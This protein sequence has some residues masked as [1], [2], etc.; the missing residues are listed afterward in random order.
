MLTTTVPRSSAKWSRSWDRIPS[1]SSS[2]WYELENETPTTEYTYIRIHANPPPRSKPVRLSACLNFWLY[3]TCESQWLTE[4][5]L[6]VTDWRLLVYCSDGWCALGDGWRT[7]LSFNL[8]WCAL[9]LPG[10]E[11][12][13]TCRLFGCKFIGHPD[14]G[15]YLWYV[16]LCERIIVYTT[17]VHCTYVLRNILKSRRPYS[18]YAQRLGLHAT[19]SYFLVALLCICG[20]DTT[21]VWVCNTDTDFNSS[22]TGHCHWLLHVR[23]AEL[24]GSWRPARWYDV[25][26]PWLQCHVFGNG[27][28]G[29]GFGFDTS[30]S[31][32]PKPLCTKFG[33]RYRRK[34]T[35]LGLSTELGVYLNWL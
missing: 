16:E 15:V 11:E 4:L 30:T 20:S 18:M 8:F 27:M 23:V 1:S 2:S 13:S 6:C 9:Y 5:Y 3:L 17:Q 28:I 31:E 7:G 33:T 35:V 34:Y 29:F 21:S 32:V 14:A 22:W 10:F 26:I 19:L 24:L 25:A 12:A